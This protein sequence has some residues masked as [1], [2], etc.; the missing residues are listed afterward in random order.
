MTRSIAALAVAF[1]LGIAS[2]AVADSRSNGIL[3]TSGTVKRVDHV[4][5]VVILDSGRKL[6]VRRILKAGELVDLRLVRPEDEIFLSGH[7][8][9]FV[10]GIARAK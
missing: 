9:G 6:E 7:D 8:L 3:L 10:P 1:S 5:R 4:N 2:T